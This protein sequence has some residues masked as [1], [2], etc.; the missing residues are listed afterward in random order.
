VCLGMMVVA[1]NAA[2]SDII[3]M[4]VMHTCSNKTQ[5]AHAVAVL[6]HSYCA[7]VSVL[8][9]VALLFLSE[10]VTA[11]LPHSRLFIL[12]WCPAFFPMWVILQLVIL[13]RLIASLSLHEVE[14]Y[15]SELEETGAGCIEAQ[16]FTW[17][18]SEGHWL[19]LLRAHQGLVKDLTAISRAISCMV[20]LF[21]N[22]VAF[23]SLLLLW[24]ARA[25]RASPASS[26]VYVLLSFIL[27]CYGLMAM[28][29][30]ARITDLCQ[31]RRLGRRSLLSLADKYSGW[32]M[33]ANVHAEYMRFMQHMNTAPAGIYVPTMGLVTRPSV[34]HKILFYIKVLPFALA[35]TM[36]W[37]RRGPSSGT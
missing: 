10:T 26:S 37:W 1:R 34:M 35:V 22:V 8:V 33:T 25:Y 15:Y 36:G 16:D 9:F 3:R 6:R 23:S 30:L 19:H 5:H 21:Q 24:V 20:L 4:L 2:Q 32:P 12:A 17:R 29:P 11:G 31:S 7:S 14:A 28:I 13:I 18:V 27:A